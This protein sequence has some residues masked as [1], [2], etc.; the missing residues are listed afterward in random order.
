[1]Y[2]AL[3]TEQ[4]KVLKHRILPHP[5]SGF[6]FTD[7]TKQPFL[8]AHGLHLLTVVFISLYSRIIKFVFGYIQA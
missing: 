4:W 8:Y 6:V 2:P 1:M 5:D 7:W 3:W